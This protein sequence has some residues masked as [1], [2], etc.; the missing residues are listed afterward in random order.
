MIPPKVRRWCRIERLAAWGILVCVGVLGLATA[1]SWWTH[2]VDRLISELEGLQSLEGR[3]HTLEALAKIGAPAVEP[4]IVMLKGPRRQLRP[5]VCQAL[6][7]IGPP[8]VKPLIATLN[9]Q[10][11]EVRDLVA[12][13]LGEI[14]DPR[15][16]QPLIAALKRA[17]SNRSHTVSDALAKIGAPSVGPL[18]VTLQNPDARV[19]EFAAE[20]LGKIR[21][22]RAVEPLIAARKD[23]APNVRWSAAEALGEI[24]D[25]RAVEPLISAL[26][27]PAPEVRWNAVKALGEIGDSRAVEPLIVVVKHPGLGL[28]DQAVKALARIG[29]PAVAPLIVTLKDPDARVRELA[30]K[31]LGGIGDS[32]AVVPLVA[33]LKN[34]DSLSGE[35]AGALVKIGAPAVEPLIAVLEDPDARVRDLAAGTLKVI[36]AP[37][38][39]QPLIVGLGAAD[40]GRRKAVAEA[41]VKIGAPAVEP[42]IAAMRDPDTGVRELAAN[43]LAEIRD[44]G[45]VELLIATLRDPDAGVRELAARTVRLIVP[46]RGLEVVPIESE[47]QIPADFK[48]ADAMKLVYGNFDPSTQ[49]SVSALPPGSEKN[50]FFDDAQGGNGIEVRPFW[51]GQAKESGASKVFLGTY[52]GPLEGGYGCHGCAP[53]IGMAIFVKTSAGWVIESSTKTAIFHGEWGKPPSAHI[54]RIGSDRVGVELVLPGFYTYDSILVPWKGEIRQAFGE[55]IAEG[56][57]QV[58]SDEDID[59]DDESLKPQPCVRT[60]KE[61]SFVKGANPDYDDMVL[62]LSG[63]TLS[64]QRPYKITEV[65]ETERRV[66]SDGKYVP[67]A[68]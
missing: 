35:V 29:A 60:Q 22:T 47:G 67:L 44:P 23:L 51:A 64:E 56:N 50:S 9:S 52:A 39:V 59:Y 4:L 30:A 21:D 41:L 18:I 13:A 26:E 12:W 32:R 55:I 20:A 57:G 17:D 54:L 36:G 40:A 66:F 43:T 68:H 53:L 28:G 19:R 31:A 46:S 5:G 27:D 24:R 3:N 63:T 11:G 45:S 2:R 7:K 37:R 58:C 48:V 65:S 1:V 15:A 6:V 33:A 8:A 16:V 49:S 61:I 34:A 62:T 42:L 10:D 25:T 38:A 14:K